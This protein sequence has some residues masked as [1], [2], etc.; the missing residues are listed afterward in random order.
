MYKS[1]PFIEAK[2]LISR[3][4]K[5]NKQLVTLES[6]YG[7]SGLPHIGTF[8]EAARTNFVIRALKKLA[9]EIQS[10]FIAFSDDMDGLRSIPENVP[11]KDMLLKEL[12]KP[13]CN[14]ADPY[15]EFE[16]YS[17]NMNNRLKIFLD[18][19]GFT[20]EFKS[21]A[22]TYRSGEFNAG[23]EQ[24]LKNYDK[25]IKIFTPTIAEDKRAAWSPFMPVC[26]NCGKNTA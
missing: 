14:I 5:Y 18:R 3:A 7:P 26:Q 8:A 23:L 22:D 17:A 6:G 13:L 1:W 19:F 15:G 24:I 16:S 4:K 25:I 9:P 21:S 11:N 10:K 2:K 20:Y 12:G